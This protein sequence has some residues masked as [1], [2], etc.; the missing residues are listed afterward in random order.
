M[1][2]LVSL[3]ILGVLALTTSCAPNPVYEQRAA[4]REAAELS[5][6]LAGRVA[7]AAQRCLPSF[8]TTNLS[9]ISDEVLL[10]R[11]GRTIWVQ[12]PRGGCSGLGSGGN[13]LVTR[14]YGTSEMCDGDFNQVVDLRTGMLAGSCVF[15]PF[16]PYTKPR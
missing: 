14:Q 11:D 13:T 16:V 7:E 2:A 6:E 10:Y 8:R 1:K 3:N 5:R 4:A 12:R 9:V 15:G